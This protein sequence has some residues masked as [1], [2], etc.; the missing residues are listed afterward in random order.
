M[1]ISCDHRFRRIAETCTVVPGQVK[2]ETPP[3]PTS[4]PT[5]ISRTA[6]FSD[7]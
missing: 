1:S 4:R 6:M 5:T 7:D 3:G 2:I